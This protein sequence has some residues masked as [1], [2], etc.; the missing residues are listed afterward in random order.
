MT[1]LLS[2]KHCSLV[3]QM[4]QSQHTS[5][6]SIPSD[7]FGVT[8]T[9]KVRI[10]T[11]H[12]RPPDPAL[13][14]DLLDLTAD[15]CPL[16]H[17]TMTSLLFPKLSRHFC[18]GPLPLLSVPLPG[19]SFPADVLQG[20]L[21]HL[22]RVHTEMS[23]SPGRLPWPLLKLAASTEGSRPRSPKPSVISSVAPD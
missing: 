1:T 12:T 17:S 14:H 13:T 7:G 18:L 6:L 16:P 5:F 22:L 9:E 23:L 3:L 4:S 11:L 2:D 19:C 20:F 15:P 10:L 21:H 8:Q